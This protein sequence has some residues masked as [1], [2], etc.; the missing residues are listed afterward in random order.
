MNN[1]ISVFGS[2]GF[3]GKRF[4]EINRT[5]CFS[6]DREDNRAKSDDVLY[7][8]STTHN[9]NIF[10]KPFL[11]IETNLTKLIEVLE[12][13]RISGRK[14]VFNFVS[15]WF[16]YGMNAT[17]DTKEEDACDPRGFYSI[18]KRAAEQMLISYCETYAI[19]YR[20]LRLTNIIGESD[21]KVSSKKNAIQYMIG[22]LVEGNS[23]KLYDGG[24]VV[25][26]F[27]YVDDACRAIEICLKN[28][29]PN[30]IVNISN[31]NPITIKAVIERI[32]KKIG[33]SSALESIVTPSFH[34]LVQIKD[35]SL[36]NAKLL[37]YGYEQKTSIETAFDLISESIINRK[38]KNGTDI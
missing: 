32:H 34:K 38:R 29:P 33:S 25:R 9:Y 27:M 11:D 22:Q 18:T 3:I 24:D 10:D 16:V 26:D 8:I 2:T 19:K 30:Q 12:N 14:G 7:L 28:A 21:E 5:N 35:V 36:N 31:N 17:L 6:I 15:S 23:V 4:C 13:Y 1:G 37:S 20:I